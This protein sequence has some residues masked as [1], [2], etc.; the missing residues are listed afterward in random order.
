MITISNIERED[1]ELEKAKKALAKMKALESKYKDKLKVFVGE[2]GCVI[3]STN[4]VHL[5]DYK[6]YIEK[7]NIL[8]KIK[9]KT[10]KD[11]SK[12]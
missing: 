12:G 8:N 5:E 9:I 6:D 10:N 3:S 2:R 11:E 1:T 7:G 4:D